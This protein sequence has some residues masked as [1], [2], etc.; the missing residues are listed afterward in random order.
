MTDGQNR[1]IACRLPE[2]EQDRQWEDVAS[3]VFGAVEETRELEDGYAFR[4]PAED[5]WV[6]AL[7]EYVLYERGCC[8]F[9]RFEVVLEADEGPTW[10]RLRGGEEVKGFLREQLRERTG[11]GPGAATPDG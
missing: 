5:R 9:F 2:E 6:R 3:E 11:S 4:F 7:T 8:P 10:L 1:E